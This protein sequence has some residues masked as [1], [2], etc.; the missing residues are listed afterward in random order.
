M[1]TFFLTVDLASKFS[2]VV[3]RDEAG[4]VR[5]QW[6]SMGKSAK[7]FA[8]SIARAVHKMES[9][10]HTV[11]VLVEDVPYGISNQ[12]MVKPVLRLQG[13]VILAMDD[14]EFY[15]INPATWQRDY[16]GVARAPKEIKSKSAKDAYRAGAAAKHALD[17]G[18]SP[19]NLVAKWQAEN[20]DTKPLKKYTNPLE[21]NMTDYVD[22][23]LIN[24]WLVRHLDDYKTISGVQPP[25][26]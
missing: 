22:A 26:I 19:P 4:Q 2:A 17:L 7:V 12:A 16:P 14:S 15:F 11:H 5:W 3:V 20:P 18:Y 13:M 9:E 21:K 25:L 24:D 8:N 23:F 1:S 10:G 6:D